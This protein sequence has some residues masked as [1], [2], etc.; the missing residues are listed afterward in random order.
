MLVARHA[1]NSSRRNTC[2][3]AVMIQVAYLVLNCYY[4]KKTSNFEQV[5]VMIEEYDLRMTSSKH[6]TSMLVASGEDEFWRITLYGKDIT[7]RYRIISLRLLTP[8]YYDCDRDLH[9]SP[10]DS[11]WSVLLS[12]WTKDKGNWFVLSYQVGNDSAPSR[13]LSPKLYLYIQWTGCYYTI[14]VSVGYLCL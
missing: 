3:L 8:G 9:H 2:P 12:V 14:S 13:L 4:S 10:D 1:V 11:Q 7:Q 5:P 6:L